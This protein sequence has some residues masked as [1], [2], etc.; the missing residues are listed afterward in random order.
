MRKANVTRKSPFNRYNDP[1]IAEGGTLPTSYA[2]HRPDPRS[3]HNFS[4]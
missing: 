1:A 2:L 4:L 3:F